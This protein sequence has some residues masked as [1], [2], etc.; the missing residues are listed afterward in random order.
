[1]DETVTVT[2]DGH[3]AYITLNRPDKLDAL[4][5]ESVDRLCA[6]LA[7]A[8]SGD[9][10]KVVVLEQGDARAGRDGASQHSAEQL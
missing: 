1:M 8:A 6:A 9:D 5:A 2:T 7:W 3:A 4:S 10:V